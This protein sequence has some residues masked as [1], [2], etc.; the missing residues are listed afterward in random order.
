M[1]A[2]N[3]FYLQS[4]LKFG[5][6]QVHAN[7]LT[8][9]FLKFS[10]FLVLSLFG[11]LFIRSD[12]DSYIGKLPKKKKEVISGRLKPPIMCGPKILKEGMHDLIVDLRRPNSIFFYSFFSD[13][14]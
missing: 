8:E 3:K 5:Q 14:F 13:T 7:S 4:K 2:L 12:E 11:L 1:G 9:S 10:D 6:L